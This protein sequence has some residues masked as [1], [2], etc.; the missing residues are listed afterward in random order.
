MQHSD[1]TILAY[2]YKTRTRKIYDHDAW[3]SFIFSLRLYIILQSMSHA[4]LCVVK[5]LPKLYE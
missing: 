3:G 4:G 2:K 5:F 1:W